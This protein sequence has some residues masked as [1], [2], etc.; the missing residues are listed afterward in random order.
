MKD[1]F[2]PGD[3]KVYEKVVEATDTAAFHGEQ[4]H[5]VCA[6]FAL[7]RDIEWASRLFVLDMREPH[8]EGVGTFLSIQHRGPARIGE[9]LRI[10]AKLKSLHK[11][12]LICS[13]EARVGDRLVATGETGQKVLHRERLASLFESD[14]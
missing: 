6:T 3:I 1:I 14:A 11:N 12:E 5:P 8:E 13:Y 9:T 10:E 2:R 7:A 4:V